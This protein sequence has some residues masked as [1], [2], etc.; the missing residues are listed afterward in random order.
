MDP[1]TFTL[2]GDPFGWPESGRSTYDQLAALH[3]SSGV[4]RGLA[5]HSAQGFNLGITGNQG[6]LI[7]FRF[8]DSFALRTLYPKFQYFLKDGDNLGAMTLELSETEHHF[9]C[10]T[11]L[12]ALFENTQLRQWF[13]VGPTNGYCVEKDNSCKLEVGG[14]IGEIPCYLQENE[15]GPSCYVSNPGSSPRTP[16]PNPP[17]PPPPHP[18]PPPPSPTPPGPAPPP[19]CF[20]DQVGYTTPDCEATIFVEDCLAPL[21]VSQRCIF[22]SKPYVMA[23]LT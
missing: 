16:P 5:S 8:W 19:E 2:N 12:H 9:A 14:A 15:F 20:T 10:S 17:P 7:D 18:S 3:V 22:I 13:A 23:F 4:V 21:Y 11:C 1:V 6:D